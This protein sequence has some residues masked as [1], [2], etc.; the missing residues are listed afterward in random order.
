VIKALGLAVLV[1]CASCGKSSKSSNPLNLKNFNGLSALDPDQEVIYQ[2]TCFVSKSEGTSTHMMARFEVKALSGNNAKISMRTV[3]FTERCEIPLFENHMQGEGVFSDNN[4]KL[5]TTIQNIFMQPLI[6]EVTDYFN[7]GGACGFYDWE[8][9]VTK[10]ITYTDC[11]E[12]NLNGNIYI[13]VKNNGAQ[14]TVYICEEN[15][16]LSN[17][18]E[19]IE[20]S[21]VSG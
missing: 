19:K 9:E 10:E 1:L 13:N 6:S 18:C 3:V 4:K 16:P 17:E 14:L 5:E 11:V 21:K 7:N 12:G 2:S 8:T 20:A 15:A